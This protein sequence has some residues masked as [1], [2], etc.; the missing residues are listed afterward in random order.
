MFVAGGCGH[1]PGSVSGRPAA[2]AG[3]E[4]PPGPARVSSPE[5]A[6]YGVPSVIA[7]LK[8]RGVTESSGVAASHLAPGVFWTHNDS[9]DG[10]YVY[11][12]DRGG[13]D[14]GV[15]R[16]T[17]AAARDWEDIAAGPGPVAGRQYLYV[18]DIGNNE[19]T[20]AQVVVYRFPEPAVTT[21]VSAASGAEPMLTEAA[22]AIT[23]RYPDGRYDAETLMVHPQTGD[24]YVITK[25]G[26]APAGVYK[27]S[28]PQ[29]VSGTHTLRRVG[30][31]GAP[32]IVAG[33]FT[34][35]DISP[36]GRRVVLC[37]YEGGYELELPGGHSDSEFDLIWS[38]PPAPVSLGP[39]RQGEA[40]C[41]SRDGS[42]LLATSE[43]QP[44]PLIEVKGDAR[45]R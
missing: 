10:P 41:Y 5:R 21:A 27:L 19:G 39:R 6:N 25:P 4:T 14:R 23:L 8:A 24:V 31:V 32:G 12:F 17:G 45:R 28:A 43:M 2:P 11:A 36:D 22:E 30:T 35:G 3:P 34:G 40:V 20:R 26:F 44:T 15:W 42:S 9:G 18:G 7:H 1:R 29:P 33:A 16:V 38:Q 13:N 37:D